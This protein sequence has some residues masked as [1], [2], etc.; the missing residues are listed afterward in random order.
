MR[1]MTC[2]QLGGACDLEFRASTFEEMA[3]KSKEHGTEMYQKQ[4]ALHL[5]AM[6]E[7]QHLMKNPEAMQEWYEA[8]KREFEALPES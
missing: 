8:K 3:E 1:I 7:M 4:D 2:R 5:Q 6:Q